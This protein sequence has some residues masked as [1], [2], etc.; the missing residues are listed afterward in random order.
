MASKFRDAPGHWRQR[1]DEMR[2]HA[3]HETD[4]DTKTMMLGIVRS[5]NKLAEM[6]EKKA[7]RRKKSTAFGLGERSAYLAYFLLARLL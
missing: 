7:T 4:L 6:A 1:S 2:A 3:D 5:Y